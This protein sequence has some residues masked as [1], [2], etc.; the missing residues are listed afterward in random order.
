MAI[1]E[2]TKEGWKNKLKTV[3][4]AHFRGC[5]ELNKWELDFTISIDLLL[6]EGKELS[7]KQSSVLSKIYA[8][9]G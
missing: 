3:Q 9:I 8:K 5:I 7:F 2:Q 6:N 4:E 1:S